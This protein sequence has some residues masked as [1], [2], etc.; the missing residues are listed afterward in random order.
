MRLTDRAVSGLALADGV[1]DV[2]LVG[3]RR[4]N[5]KHETTQH[6]TGDDH[7]IA[8]VEN[9]IG[10]RSSRHQRRHITVLLLFGSQR[11]A[12]EHRLQSPEQISGVDHTVDSDIAVVIDRERCNRRQD[13]RIHKYE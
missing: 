11:A 3:G 9:T 10:L 13:E 5:G 6:E 8:Q 7:H 12:A 2:E 1:P 4:R